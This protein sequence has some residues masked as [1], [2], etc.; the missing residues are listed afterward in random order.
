MFP[1]LNHWVASGKV[2]LF[3]NSEE[4]QV[5]SPGRPHPDQ[6]RSFQATLLKLLRLKNRTGHL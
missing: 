3:L 6:T 2:D 5:R 1:S 4:L